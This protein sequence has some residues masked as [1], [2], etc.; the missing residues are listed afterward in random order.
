MK[1][2]IFLTDILQ[3]DL[4][5][6]NKVKT[7]NEILG[8]LRDYCTGRRSKTSLYE[9]TNTIIDI[10][11]SK[12]PL[13]NLNAE[14]TKEAIERLL[15]DIQEKVLSINML[16]SYR[17]TLSFSPAA[18]DCVNDNYYSLFKL[19]NQIDMSVSMGT[20]SQAE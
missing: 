13:V 11:S 4:S 19:C 15:P 17:R 6:L 7:A 1:K 2:A 14:Q 9:E 18:I 20:E 3:L 5:P 8:Y 10:F 12:E 16:D